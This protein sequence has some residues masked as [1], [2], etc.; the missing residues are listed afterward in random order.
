MKCVA[1]DSDELMLE[2]LGGPRAR[3]VDEGA[4]CCLNCERV[5]PV[6][7]GIIENSPDRDKQHDIWDDLYRKA[8]ESTTFQRQITPLDKGFRERE[9]LT[10]YYPLVRTVSLFPVPLD[11][12]VELGSGSGAYSLVLKK[13]GL[14]KRVTLLD[15]SIESLH[16]AGELF[17]YFGESCTLV[18]GSIE[19]HPFKDNAFNL[20]FSGGVI[21]HYHTG[22]ERLACMEA[23][24]DVAERA[25]I[26]APVNS[27]CYWLQRALV[28]VMERGWPFGYERPVTIREMYQLAKLAGAKIAHTDYHFFLNAL[29]FRIPRFIDLKRFLKPVWF[30]RPMMTELAVLLTRDGR[31]LIK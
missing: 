1:C 6:I 3:S 5:M 14:V 20:S 17:R 27:P 16:A 24:L 2:S 15:Y 19:S 25:F 22:E 31:G 10:T 4:L 30:T 12:S 29:I 13:L 23:H 11:S 26:Q 18:H 7:Q 21:E 9:L 8:Q 28:T